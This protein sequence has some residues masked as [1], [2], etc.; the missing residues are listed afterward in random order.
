MRRAQGSKVGQLAQGPETYAGPSLR[1]GNWGD[2]CLLS[3][4]VHISYHDLYLIFLIAGG[5]EGKTEGYLTKQLACAL[6]K[7][8]SLEKQRQAAP[9]WQLSWLEPHPNVPR[10]WVRSPIG[11]HTRSTQ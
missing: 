2:F 5:W 3:Y 4:I 8:Q 9:A 6:Q 11:A 1:H 7:G 10:L